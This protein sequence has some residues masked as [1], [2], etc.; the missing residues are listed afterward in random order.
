MIIGN[1]FKKIKNKYD[2]IV[3]GAG[4]AG[5]EASFAASNLGFSTALITLNEDGIGLAP[6]NPSVGGPAKGIV[7][8]EIDALGG[9]QGV[10]ADINQLQM[11]LLNSS[12]GPGVW[13]LRAQID[14]IEYH[15]WFINEV[16]KQS[17]LDVIYGEVSS[18]KTLNNIILG[19]EINDEINIEAQAVILTTGTYL[20]SVCHQGETNV[21]SGPDGFK[22]AESLSDSL[23]ELGFNLIRLKTGT[24]PRILKDSIDYTKFEYEPG[25]N[26]KLS[27]SHFNKHFVPFD[28]Q[29]P[30]WILHTTDKTKEIIEKNLKRSAMYG[31]Y[32]KTA[33]GPRYCPSIEDKVVKFNDKPCYQ[34]FVEPES[35]HLDT[36]YL[37]GFSTSMPIDVQDE[38]IRSLPGFENCVVKK[39]AYAIEYDAIDPTQLYPSLES[40]L[41]KGLFF[42]GQ[43]NGT[44][45][46][47]EAAGQGLIA[48]IN[49][50]QYIKKQPPLILKRHESYIGVMIDD[51]VTKGITEPY[52]LLT[53][54]A[55][56][57]LAL[58]NDNALDRLIKYGYD[59]GLVKQENYD[60]Y[61]KQNELINDIITKLKN[62]YVGQIKEL[63]HV[64]KN[65][66]TLYDYL[67]R[68]EVLIEN[69]LSFIGIDAIT[70]DQEILDKIQIQIKFEGYIKVQNENLERLSNLDKYDLTCIVDYQDV[71]N[72]TLEAIDKLNKIK[73]INLD[74]A[75][76]ISGINLTDIARIKYYLD[77][78]KNK[79]K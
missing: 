49:A 50:V 31:G 18:L 56:H 67:K 41:I 12:K 64:K 60:L 40:K 68:P 6:C 58:R 37:D 8:R 36:I 35:K 62:V 79:E 73:P 72:I 17:N 2:V 33:V 25:T 45:G 3:V 44:S 14:K 10:A 42:A 57:R 22:R 71:P 27:F 48:G 7:T 43:I 53:S 16:K 5:L 11:K 21:K 52:R 47:E 51:I 70:I 30:C 55:E 29:E 26:K 39:Y 34:L 13:A 54:R 23:I 46:Y 20:K 9:M 24:P 76:R 77:V 32:I 59:I 4:H 66:A 63:S 1:D 78:I 69:V 65:N 15:N 38:M 61:L 28:E 74:Q 19:I 75:S